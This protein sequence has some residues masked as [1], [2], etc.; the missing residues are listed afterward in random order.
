MIK[1]DLTTISNKYY[2]NQPLHRHCVEEI[3]YALTKRIN[4]EIFQFSFR[5]QTVVDDLQIICIYEEITY[6]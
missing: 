6:Q 4:N 5:N 2:S 1:H 3:K